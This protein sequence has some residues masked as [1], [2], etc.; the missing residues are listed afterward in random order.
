MK[1]ET[2]YFRTNLSPE[3]IQGMKDF[4]KSF[5]ELSERI[6]AMGNSRETSLAFTH[7][8]QALSYT[9]KHICLVDPNAQK[10]ILE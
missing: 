3:S 4:R 8:E 6:E 7:L 5:I 10:E 1:T 9:I 2:L